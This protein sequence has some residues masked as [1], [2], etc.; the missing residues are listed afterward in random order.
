[1]T[2][3]RGFR[4]HTYAYRHMGRRH[5]KVV[6][7]GGRGAYGYRHHSRLRYAHYGHRAYGYRAYGYRGYRGCD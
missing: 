7:A 4:T 5:G 6:G 2:N 1:M 3:A